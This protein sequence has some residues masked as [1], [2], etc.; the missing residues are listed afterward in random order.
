MHISSVVLLC[1]I[2]YMYMAGDGR[3]T[4]RKLKLVCPGTLLGF[5]ANGILC[6]HLLLGGKLAGGL[7]IGVGHP[8]VCDL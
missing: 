6:T 7:A 5:Q 4:G 1:F 3:C 8:D 2:P